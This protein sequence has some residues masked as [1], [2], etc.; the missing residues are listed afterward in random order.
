MGVE[1]RGEAERQRRRERGRHVSSFPPLEASRFDFVMRG[2]KKITL[3]KVLRAFSLPLSPTSSLAMLLA[4][5]P[6]R[7]L[8]PSLLRPGLAGSTTSAAARVPACSNRFPASI[9]RPSRHRNHQPFAASNNGGPGDGDDDD[10]DGPSSFDIDALASALSR[11]AEERRRRAD[12]GGDIEEGDDSGA[13]PVLDT[14]TPTPTPPPSSSSA[15]FSPSSSSSPFGTGSKQREAEV[16]EELGGDGGFDPDEIE[17]VRVTAFGFWFSPFFLQLQPTPPPS[18]PPLLFTQTLANNR[19]LQELG[20]VSWITSESSSRNSLNAPKTAAA[21]YAAR[22]NPPTPLMS[23]TIVLVK[24][25]F[26]HASS[27]ACNELQVGARLS[28]GGSLPARKWH[29]ARSD[30]PPPPAPPAAL[31]LLGWFEAASAPSSASQ[32]EEAEAFG[33][34]TLPSPSTADPDAR[35]LWL[36]FKWVGGQPL[37]FYA[38]QQQRTSLR[39]TGLAALLPSALSSPERALAEALRRRAGMVRRIASG[40]TAALA[41]VHSAG[42]AHGSLGGGL[43]AAVDL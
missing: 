33:A 30:G 35:S 36:V 27:L 42:V 16:L 10:D 2:K 13:D 24:E 20:R 25:Y 29:A 7:P 11:A 34:G 15:S 22:Y 1:K 9:G 8:A 28:S 38:Q 4:G 14:P 23:P 6:S 3:F 37:S 31:P 40:A 5:S 18:P 17:L 21:V 39:A 41:R 32:E 43:R 19:Q 12:E 26:P